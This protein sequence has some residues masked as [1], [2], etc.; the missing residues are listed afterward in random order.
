MYLYI[1]KRL[2]AMIPTLLG[3]TLITFAIIN[4]APGDP[5]AAQIGQG[6]S[7]LSAEGAGSGNNLQ[8]QERMQ[9]AIKAKKK[10]LGMMKEDY[11]LY[12]WEIGVSVA[13]SEAFA[14]LSPS[15]TS[16]SMPAWA[17]SL[18]VTDDG[19]TVYAATQ[20]GE[21]YK[22][23]GSD[24]IA[25]LG[26]HWHSKGIDALALSPDEALLLSAD[27]EGNVALWNTTSGE[28]V[29][30]YTDSS[31]RFRD[32]QFTSDG[33]RAL[34]GGDSGEVWVLDVPS[35][36]AKHTIQTNKR[37][38]TLM[39]SPD[40]AHIWVSGLS[41]HLA[42]YSLDTGEETRTGFRHGQTVN[43]MALSPDGK[44]LATAC[45]DRRIY[46]VDLSHTWDLESEDSQP[47]VIG[48]HWAG[49]SS[50][51]WSE[52][53][54]RLIS[55]SR[56]ETVR[57]WDLSDLEQPTEIGR[58]EKVGRVHAVSVIGDQVIS[59]SDSWIKVPIWKQ[60]TRWLQRIAT[61]DF[62]RSFKDDV[63]VIDKIKK[64][65]P[66]TVGLNLIALTIIYLVSIPLGVYAAVK[67]NGWF[68]QVSSII[69]FLLYSIPNF[70]LAT[71]LIMFFASTQNWDILPAA[72]LSVATADD[73]SYLDWLWDRVQHLILPVIVLTY[74]G[75]ASLSRY[76]RTTM[77]ETIQ[78]DYVRTARAKGL[79]ESVVIY[80]HA[81]RNSLITIV[82]LMGNLL[83]AM[84]GGSVIVEVIFSIDGMG[85]LGF[86]AILDRDYPV[87]MAITTFSA[88]IT[89]VGILISDILY[90]VVD[91]RVSQE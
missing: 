85:K 50:I 4:L 6:G 18:A 10:L 32:A 59:A 58:T 76:A 23:Q 77:L 54:T 70:W 31:G 35:L 46:L 53:G 38:Y 24:S 14:T 3:I 13:G 8:D 9:D 89:L 52:D 84:I 16:A 15:E 20:D 65:L 45:E 83:P 82:T 69:L 37:V 81:F 47:L 29:A 79:S 33:T 44:W 48:E 25:S 55:G 71:M 67:R 12:S 39:E 49:V 88:F 7:E 62:D 66:V 87:I 1:L 57:I 74:A 2:L 28:K 27:Q 22:V 80:K 56:D 17:R 51:A 86:Q 75:F 64:A 43:D 36:E 72:G 11:R 40:G 5:V 41:R 61:F 63:P 19:S 60:Y 73:L 91:P 30:E 68:D 21:I 34:V 90:S 26:E 78:E 42:E